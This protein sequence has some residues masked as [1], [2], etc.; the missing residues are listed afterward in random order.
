MVLVGVIGCEKNSDFSAGIP[1][2][3]PSII[4]VITTVALPDVLVEENP[5]ESSGSAKA[6]V[7]V[8]AETRI[9]RH[10]GTV[11]GVSALH[12]GQRARVWFTG[13]VAESYPVQATGGVIVIDSGNIVAVQERHEAQLMAISG[14]VG[15]GIGERDGAEVIVVFVEEQTATI[16]QN[17]PNTLDGYP[18]VIEVTGPIDAFNLPGSKWRLQGWSASSLDPS[19]FTITADFSESQISGTSAVNSYGGPYTATGDGRFSVGDMQS[20]LMGGSEDAMGAESL[21]FDLL[22]QARKYLIDGARLILSDDR[23]NPLLMFN[24]R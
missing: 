12:A 9:L 7:R 18:V 21:Y 14:V 16:E 5:A 13:P 11:A 24:R 20:T 17:V 6:S 10:D 8:T 15:S 22:H 19:R 4:G 1:R 2:N 23:G 3:P